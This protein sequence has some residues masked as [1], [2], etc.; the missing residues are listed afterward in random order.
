MF[1]IF[2]QLPY[3]WL[4]IWSAPADQVVPLYESY[5]I[6][7][8]F[9]FLPFYAVTLAP[10]FLLGVKIKAFRKIAGYLFVANVIFALAPVVVPAAIAYGIYRL[11]RAGYYMYRGTTPSRRRA[12]HRPAA[13]V[14]NFTDLFGGEDD[15]EEDEDG[16]GH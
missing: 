6:G 7:T 10:E 4:T 5:V 12:R 15:E 9:A 2:T 14:F 13:P 16:H 1:Q 8:L 11:A 3:F